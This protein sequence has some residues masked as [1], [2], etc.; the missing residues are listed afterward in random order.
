MGGDDMLNTGDLMFHSK[1]VCA[2]GW[3]SS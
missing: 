1:T 2:E 3:Q